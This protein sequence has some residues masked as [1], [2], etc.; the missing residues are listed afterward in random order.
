MPRSVDGA[1]VNADQLRAAVAVGKDFL[2]QSDVYQNCLVGELD[3][4]KTQAGTR[5]PCARSGARKVGQPDAGQ[6]GRQPED[7][8]KGR[9]RDQR[10]HRCLQAEPNALG[11]QSKR[12][13]A[14]ARPADAFCRRRST[15]W[16]SASTR[17]RAGSGAESRIMPAM[18]EAAI[19][20]PKERRQ[21]EGGTAS[22]TAILEAARRVAA[23]D[24][25]RDLSPARRGR[26]SR[27]RA[28][29]ALRLFPQQGRIA[30]G[31]GGRRSHPAGA[32]DAWPG[33]LAGAGAAALELLCGAET[34][35]AAA[36]R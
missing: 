19:Q 22:R 16:P 21:R 31:A 9:R 28:G 1:N 30:A 3:A 4:A 12:R 26:G 25:A 32:G 34:M 29:R 13:S 36:P 8:G 15:Q 5:R 20:I 23:R 18:A 7:Q 33:G 24:G 14:L 27:F 11:A 35:A 6:A 2:A 17:P 10:R